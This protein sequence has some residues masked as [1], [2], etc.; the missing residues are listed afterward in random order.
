LLA[1]LSS[2][3]S[4]NPEMLRLAA[5]HVHVGGKNFRPCRERK[6]LRSIS[7]GPS[8]CRIRSPILHRKF[9]V[10]DHENNG[11]ALILLIDKPDRELQF[12]SRAIVGERS[13][14]RASG[15]ITGG[16]D[17]CSHGLWAVAGA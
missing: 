15:Q 17:R 8:S 9:L 1:A 5:V 13:F 4:K 11:L 7:S 3:S 16:C 14:R 10:A 6:R 12:G 2:F